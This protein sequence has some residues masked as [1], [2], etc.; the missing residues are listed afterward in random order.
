MLAMLN[1]TRK[2]L[3]YGVIAYSSA[4]P[5]LFSFELVYFADSAL[6]IFGLPLIPW[7][8]VI[9]A[10]LIDKHTKIKTDWWV[11]G[12]ALISFYELAKLLWF[13]VCYRLLYD[14]GGCSN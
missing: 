13:G 3:I 7:L 8:I 10:F 6:L 5:P 9:S 1:I 11:L 4:V 2:S 12:S 14:F